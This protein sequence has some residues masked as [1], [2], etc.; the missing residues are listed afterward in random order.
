[1]LVPLVDSILC[2]IFLDSIQPNKN[3]QADIHEFDTMSA[4]D[5][6]T[7]IRSLTD[8][9]DR[10]LRRERLVNALL[11]HTKKNVLSTLYNYTKLSDSD[12]ENDALKKIR[13]NVQFGLLEQSYI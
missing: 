7:H 12:E 2:D 5:P 11:L 10:L 3:L 1:M 8:S 13:A 6:R 4:D 9:N